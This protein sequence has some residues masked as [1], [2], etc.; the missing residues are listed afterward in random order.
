[1]VF[2]LLTVAG[3][4]ANS[5]PRDS[6]LAG[7]PISDAKAQKTAIERQLA[8]QRARL[9]NLKATAATLASQLDLAKAELASVSAEYDRV[10]GL[11]H[12]VEQQVAEITARLE[13]LHQEIDQLDEQLAGVAADI[14]LQTDDL[15]AREALLE[16]HLRSAYEQSQTSLLEVML[17]SDSLDAATN[18]VGYLLTVSEQDKALAEEIR[19]IRDELEVKQ[20]TLRDGRQALRESRIAASE[21]QKLLTER[22][23]ELQ[24]LEAETARLKAAAEKK[25]A[26]QEAALNAAVQAK[27]NVE[28]QI[29]ANEKSFVAASQLV[30]RLVAEQAAIEEAKRRAAEEARKKAQ[31]ISARG[32]RWPEAAPRITQEWGPTSFTLEPPYTYNGTYYAHFHAG[33]DMASGCGSPILAA[34]AGVV[35]ASGRPLWPYDP[36]YGVVLD[37]GSGVKT[38]YWHMQARV[39]VSPGQIV[40][41]G[42]VIG[43]EGSTG[44]STGCH[45][46]FAVNDNGVWQNPR[47][48]LP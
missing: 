32:F 40:N 3:S 33:I 17:S 24:Q 34:K 35:V 31:Q 46:H 27:G 45:L 4:F 37:H 28:A 9:A 25:R 6:A 44:F 21:Q 16:D 48:Y 41:T 47:W 23:A 39:I 12:Q 7:D 19:V 29:A 18:Q 10:V 11:L 26:D 36:G 2:A 30:D 1:M 38:W 14:T 5:T 15:N 8:D 42:Q 20:R 43:Y 22:Q 13:Q